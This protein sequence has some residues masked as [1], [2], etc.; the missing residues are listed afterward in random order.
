VGENSR[1]TVGEGGAVLSTD[2][3]G[4]SIDVRVDRNGVRVES[5]PPPE[6]QA[7]GP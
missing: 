6:P 5:A 1:L 2:I 4:V 7:A 3:R